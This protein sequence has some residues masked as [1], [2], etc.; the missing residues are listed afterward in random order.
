[1]NNKELEEKVNVS[2][3]ALDKAQRVIERLNEELGKGAL[4]LRDLERERD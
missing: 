4:L 3:E 2:S 1:M